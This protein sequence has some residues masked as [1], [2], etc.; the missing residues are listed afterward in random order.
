[1][2]PTVGHSMQVHQA[3]TIHAFTKHAT[4]V[5]PIH[6]SQPRTPGKICDT[7]KRTSSLAATL[8]SVLASGLAPPTKLDDLRWEQVDLRENPNLRHIKTC[9]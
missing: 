8:E 2:D 4:R 3:C 6:Q 5:S 1:M 9:G 7:A